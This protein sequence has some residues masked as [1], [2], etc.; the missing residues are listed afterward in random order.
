VWQHQLIIPTETLA[1]EKSSHSTNCNS[2]CDISLEKEI[3]LEEDMN[4]K[5]QQHSSDHDSFSMNLLLGCENMIPSQATESIGENNGLY[6]IANDIE[7]SYGMDYNDSLL[8]SFQSSPGIVPICGS[9]ADSFTLLTLDE[10][11]TAE[12]SMSALPHDRSHLEVNTTSYGTQLLSLF[13]SF[14]SFDKRLI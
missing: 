1:V 2:H 11:I 6:S 4:C 13:L 7:N 3:L 12:L 9:A 5:Q 8:S 14:C 10:A